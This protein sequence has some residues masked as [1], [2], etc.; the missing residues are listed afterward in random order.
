MSIFYKK[1]DIA[2]SNFAGKI[3]SSGA[4]NA[5]KSTTNVFTLDT[6]YASTFT[7]LINEKPTNTFLYTY[8]NTDISEYCIATY[9]ES[10]GTT[11][12]ELPT[13][14]NKVRAILI[15]GG[16]GGKTGTAGT[17]NAVVP[18]VIYDHQHKQEHV[19]E[20]LKANYKDF[21][22]HVDSGT[23]KAAIPASDNT[24]AS[25]G[26]GGGGAFIYLNVVDITANK[27]NFAI[28]LGTAGG[29]ATAGNATT[30]TINSN[31]IYTAGGGGGSSGTGAGTR[32]NAAGPTAS[33]SNPGNA[34][35]DSSTRTAGTS[36]LTAIYSNNTT[37]KSYGT[38]GVGTVG[39]T[40]P[41]AVTAAEGGSDGY[42]R[43]YF[44]TS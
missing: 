13:W 35:G 31:T 21:D 11:F 27:A 41:N 24:G 40:G 14:C 18:A 42:Y 28:A 36:G 34:G 23:D 15:G 38:G 7:S 3:T 8:Q 5:F 12:S 32:G 10:S 19:H 43:I 4:Y 22:R 33:Y 2:I 44:L 20:F 37:A 17:K 16:G 39:T 25:G 30:L 29:V 1:G 26:G 6:S 9:V